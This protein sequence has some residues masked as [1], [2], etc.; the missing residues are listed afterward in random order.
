LAK[1]GD[2]LLR[3]EI[4]EQ[5]DAVARLISREEGRVAR[6]SA[7]GG[8]PEAELLGLSRRLAARRCP[9]LPIGLP[10]RGAIPLPDVPELLSPLVAVVPGQLLA[11]W[12][13]VFRGLDPDHP[14]R[15]HKVTETR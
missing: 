4:G 12:A 8:K 10:R 7:P 14:R 9:V 3:R 6:V 1:P 13:A 11:L 15:L 5:P 2:W